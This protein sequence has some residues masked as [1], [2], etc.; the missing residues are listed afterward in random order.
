MR[1]FVAF[2][3][4]EETQRELRRVREELSGLPNVRWVRLEGIHLTVKFIGEIDD[5][6]VPEVFKA[7]ERSVEG[8]E[9]FEFRVKGLGYFPPRRMPRVLWAGVEEDDRRFVE[10]AD[11][12]N[13]EL[14]E[15]GVKP[16]KRDFIPHIT[17]GRVRGRIDKEEVDEAF[18]ERRERQFGADEASELLL[19]MSEL[20]PEGARY[21]KMGAVPLA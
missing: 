21:T 19:Y 12:L 20:H 2:D 17:L 6:V 10:I 11:R 4:N 5:P 7:M 14:A 15:L 13:S 9:A 1:T 18:E 16:E 3:V 8:I